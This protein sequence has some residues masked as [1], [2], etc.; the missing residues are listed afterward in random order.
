[1]IINQ[2]FSRHHLNKNTY[3]DVPN[4]MLTLNCLRLISYKEIYDITNTDYKQSQI[5]H[6][7]LAYYKNIGLCKDPIVVT[8]DDFCLDGRH[9]I[10]Y[11]NNISETTCPAYIIP[12]K[13]VDK[14]IVKH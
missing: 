6:N 4:L 3:I 9:R 14:F 12:R 2:T 8:D 10:I 13:Y 7:V 1:M 11:R 5:N